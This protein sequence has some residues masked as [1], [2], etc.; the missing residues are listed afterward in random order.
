MI[1]PN[2]LKLFAKRGI[3]LREVQNRVKIY[4]GTGEQEAEIDMLLIN[5]EYSIAL[6][7]KTTLNID[8]VN[9]HL[10]RLDRIQNNPPKG[11]IGTI[12]LGAVT[13]LRI[14]EQADKFAY[15][16]GLFILK[17]KGEIVDIANDDKFNPRKWKIKP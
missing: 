13:G 15:R 5:S 14:E 8:A 7:V 12:L 6:E 17:Q 11:I 2:I 9:E 3:K 10:E 1:E 16:K 4:K